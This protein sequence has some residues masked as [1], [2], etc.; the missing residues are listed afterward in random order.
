MHTKN[1]K[2]KSNV[3]TIHIYNNYIMA[4]NKYYSILILNCI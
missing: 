2:N 1:I 3:D 4:F